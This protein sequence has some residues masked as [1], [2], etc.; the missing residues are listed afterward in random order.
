MPFVVWPNN[1]QISG[2]CN[3]SQTKKAKAVSFTG[4]AITTSTANVCNYLTASQRLNGFDVHDKVLADCLFLSM[5]N[6]RKNDFSVVWSHPVQSHEKKRCARIFHNCLSMSVRLLQVDQ[7]NCTSCRIYSKRATKPCHVWSCIC[8]FLPILVEAN[9]SKPK[10]QKLRWRDDADR[11]RKVSVYCFDGKV[12]IL[13][14]QQVVV[15]GGGKNVDCTQSLLISQKSSCAYYGSRPSSRNCIL[16]SQFTTCPSSIIKA[17]EDVERL[18]FIHRLKAM[19]YKRRK[20][21]PS[22]S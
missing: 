12:T 22:P 11:H 21:R 9:I 14:S 5:K 8:T 3:E 18:C 6:A 10:F 17:A 19:S 13:E 1:L 20:Q 4:Q 16:G 2:G 7:Y 15:G